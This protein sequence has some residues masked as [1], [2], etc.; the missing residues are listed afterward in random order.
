MAMLLTGLTC[1]CDGLVLVN[2][3][4]ATNDP[5]ASTLAVDKHIHLRPNNTP[6]TCLGGHTYVIE[7]NLLMRRTE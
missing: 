4:L 2:L 3:S 5:G 6:M 1:P 7:G